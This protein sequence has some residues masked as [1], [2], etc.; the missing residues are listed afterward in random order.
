MTSLHAI[1]GVPVVMKEL[2]RAGLLHGDV[3][4]VTGRTLAENLETVPTLEQIGAGHR[5][6]GRKP[7]APP[8]T[9]SA[10]SRAI[11]RRRAAC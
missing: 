9:T 7:V 4:T 6:A 3:M 5:A 10:C 11:S 8:T 1:G 2:L